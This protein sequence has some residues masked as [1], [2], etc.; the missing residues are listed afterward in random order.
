MRT[1]WQQ[2]YLRRF[3][4]PERGWVD[5]TTEFHELCA[6]T[7]P[8]G[9]R[10]LEV[11]AGPSNETS[12]FVGGLG[13]LQEIR[14][15]LKPGAPYIFRTPNVRHFVYAIASVTPH[16][17]HRAVAN[18]LRNLPEEAHDPYPTVYAMNSSSKV[19]SLATSAGFSVE[20]LRLVEKEPSYG[21]ASP[22]LFIPFMVYERVVNATDLLANFRAMI[23][24]VLRKA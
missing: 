24:S 2:R 23:F 1:S 10:I 21:M 3:Y 11:G 13:E 5:G 15:V 8:R 12:D 7:I 17:F 20:Q 6:S 16:S 14:R 18:P 9:A 4:N 19:Q 22:V